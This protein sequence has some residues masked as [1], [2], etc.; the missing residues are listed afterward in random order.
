MT[1]YTEARGRLEED[2]ARLIRTARDT[3]TVMGRA[4][5][6]ETI[7]VYVLKAV[8]TIVEID[9]SLGQSTSSALDIMERIPG[10]RIRINGTV[11]GD[12]FDDDA[13]RDAKAPA[14][15]DPEKEKT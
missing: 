4:S 10:L 12:L 5:E 9:G 1:E 11:P 6:Y 8:G 14:A 15:A 3:M 2:A 13:V 7:L